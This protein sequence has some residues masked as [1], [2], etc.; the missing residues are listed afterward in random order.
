MKNILSIVVPNYNHVTF[1]PQRLKS[2]FHQSF[3]NFEVILLD[4]ASTDGSQELLKQYKTHSKV[5]HLVINEV[6]SGSPFRQW[7]KGISLASGEYIWIAES[8]D[9]NDVSFLARIFEKMKSNIGLCYSQ[10]I[11]VDKNGEQIFHREDYT[12]TFS[13]NIWKSDFTIKGVNFIKNYLIVKNV[14]P[15]AS[16][17]VFR[18]DLVDTS[19]FSEELLNMRMCGDWLFWMH[20]CSK[21][22]IAF[23]ATPLNYFRNHQDVSRMHTTSEKKKSRLVEEAALRRNISKTTGIYSENGEGMLYKQWFALHNF[24]TIWKSDFYSIIM[25]RKS[26]LRFILDFLNSKIK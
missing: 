21:T 14:I 4:D 2:I 7:Q 6:N 26:R 22:D 24:R 18:R 13:P 9:Y 8:D 12:N 15:N 23:I 17:V 1:L 20:L 25:N 19:F 16:A 11:D 5:S 10:T 3:K